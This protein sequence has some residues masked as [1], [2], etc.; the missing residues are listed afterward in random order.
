[1][2]PRNGRYPS[3]MT[4]TSKYGSGLLQGSQAK[5]KGSPLEVKPHEPLQSFGLCSFR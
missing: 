1:M 4:R 2:L 3:E 5:E